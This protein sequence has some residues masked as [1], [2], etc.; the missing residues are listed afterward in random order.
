[1][2]LQGG[3]SSTVAWAKRHLVVNEICVMMNWKTLFPLIALCSLMD[4]HADLN[5]GIRA[6]YEKDY[7]TAR[8]EF[9]AA[10]KA[11]GVAG[12]HMMASL[13][14]QGY[15]VEKD[16]KEAVRLYTEAAGKGYRASQANLGLMYHNGDGV[17][18]DI[19]KAIEYYTAAGK[20]GDLQSAYNLGQIFR[21]GDGVEKNFT[22]AAGYYKFAAE[23]GHVPA[24]NEYGLLYAQGQGVELNYVE[25]YGW[26]AY[27]AKSGDGQ[28][29]KNLA[30]L[31]QILGD[32]IDLAKKRA[33]EVE[34]LIKKNQQ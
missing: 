1:M 26:M 34:A 24:V 18:R 22:K 33:A 21:K 27:A 6:Y 20:Q 4:V 28:A 14:Y 23:Y 9:E 10:A 15:G 29:K 13:Y 30:Q 32:K 2:G 19:K 31:E 8:K 16:L 17:E 25:S 11:G 3:L 7:D 12:T 5:E